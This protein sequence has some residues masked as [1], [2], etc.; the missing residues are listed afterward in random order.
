MSSSW[1]HD[2]AHTTLLTISVVA[3]TLVLWSIRQLV[4]ERKRLARASEERASAGNIVLNG[5][6]QDKIRF[7][8]EYGTSSIPKFPEW[9]EVI[10]RLAADSDVRVISAL[11]NHDLLPVETL[12]RWADHPHLEVGMD[13]IRHKIGIQDVDYTYLADYN[14]KDALLTELMRRSPNRVVREEA[15]SMFRMREQRRQFLK[16]QCEE[17][18]REHRII[19]ERT[20]LE[21]SS[22]PSGP[23]LC[24]DHGYEKCQYCSSSNH[25]DGRSSSGWV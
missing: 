5:S 6:C 7:I 18:E 21:R 8:N 2:T 9:S 12:V 17:R 19:L 3:V 4:R 20:A 24:A 1:F 16:R 23:Q 13:L 10:A 22:S 15:A 11:L 14:Y 25:D